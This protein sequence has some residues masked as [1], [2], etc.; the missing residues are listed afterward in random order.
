MATTGLAIKPATRQ[1]TM[2]RTFVTILLLALVAGAVVAVYK[3]TATPTST[4]GQATDS[5]RAIVRHTQQERAESAP[6]WNMIDQSVVRFLQSERSD[7]SS[8]WSMIDSS[9]LNHLRSER[10]EA[11]SDSR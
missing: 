9:V 6:A 5:D 8:N 3:F 7:A 1:S 10:D 11:A 2:F 4:A